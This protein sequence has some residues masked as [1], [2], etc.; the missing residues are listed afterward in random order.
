MPSPMNS[1]SKEKKQETPREQNKTAA[2][3]GKRLLSLLLLRSH[4]ILTPMW[5]KADEEVS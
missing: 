3:H 4:R 5:R 1:G 2:E